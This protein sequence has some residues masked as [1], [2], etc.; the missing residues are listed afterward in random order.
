MSKRINEQ[1]PNRQQS[2][3]VLKEEMDFIVGFEKRVIKV[4]KPAQKDPRAF[5]EDVTLLYG[6]YDELIDPPEIISYS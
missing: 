2:K 5:W 1:E 3:F 6:V 4:I